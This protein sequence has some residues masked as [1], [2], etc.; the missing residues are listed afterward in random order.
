MTFELV[1][2]TTKSAYKTQSRCDLLST[3]I[4]L[5]TVDLLG[6][7]G[8]GRDVERGFGVAVGE[9]GICTVGEQ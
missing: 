3:A 1:C 7:S 2:T 5:A 8:G 9:V 4:V 6:N